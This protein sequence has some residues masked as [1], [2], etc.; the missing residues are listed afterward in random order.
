MLQQLAH[1]L[2]TRHL[3]S[4]V[5][6]EELFYDDDDDTL[7]YP[8]RYSASGLMAILVSRA[9]ELISFRYQAASSAES[10]H[11]IMLVKYH[12]SHVF[13]HMVRIMACPS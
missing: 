1:L 8:L 11:A 6:L 5:W 2:M 13:L 10:H 4:P 9:D 3:S 12:I 7:Q